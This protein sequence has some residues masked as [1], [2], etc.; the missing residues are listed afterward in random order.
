MVFL[1]EFREGTADYFFTYKARQICCFQ[2]FFDGTFA[3]KQTG[4]PL[5][6]Y[7]V[8]FFVGLFTE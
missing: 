5:C 7:A 4:H 8:L 1:C 3:I 6:G 2:P